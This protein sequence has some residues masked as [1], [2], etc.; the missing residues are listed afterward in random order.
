[1]PSLHRIAQAIDAHPDV[2]AVLNNPDPVSARELGGIRRLYRRVLSEGLEKEHYD[3]LHAS[4][5]HERVPSRLRDAVL[6]VCENR[7]LNMLLA[8][9]EE[10]LCLQLNLHGRRNSGEPAS[11]SKDDYF[12]YDQGFT[13]AQAAYKDQ[14]YNEGNRIVLE[15]MECNP[16]LVQWPN[17]I[18]MAAVGAHRNGHYAAACRLARHYLEMRKDP[19]VIRI[20]IHSANSLGFFAKVLKWGRRHF[21]DLNTV[22]Q[23]THSPAEP[24]E[25]CAAAAMKLGYPED[26]LRFLVAA[27]A[28]SVNENILA[29]MA[30]C[31]CENQLSPEALRQM[32]DKCPPQTPTAL[33]RTLAG[34]MARQSSP[35]IQA[36]IAML[37]EIRGTGDEPAF[38]SAP[39]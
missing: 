23:G 12:R 22:P 10:A 1:M 7:R 38:A 9:G 35:K 21:D 18:F 4:L 39:L 36:V 2:R 5:L 15:M 11:P 24:H 6:E 33:I 25:F 26:A 32:L 28:L 17:L 27:S 37:Q 30:C 31:L 29:L 19:R 14:H 20:G 8:L 3:N 16:R 34:M 13:H